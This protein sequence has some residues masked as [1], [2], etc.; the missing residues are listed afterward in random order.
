MTDLGQFL[1]VLEQEA[2]AILRRSSDWQRPVSTVGPIFIW[3][4]K[5]ADG[6]LA[7]GGGDA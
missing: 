7:P 3:L 1:P 6:F 4:R 2:C 5:Q